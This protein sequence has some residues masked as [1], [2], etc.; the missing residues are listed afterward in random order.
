MSNPQSPNPA[1]RPDL[2]LPTLRSA[3]GDHAD[4]HAALD[5]FHAEFTGATPSPER[6]GSHAERLR[7][8]AAVAGPFERWW[9][10][11]KVQAFIAGLEAT[12]V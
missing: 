4:A 11:P 3:A 7:G 12:G 8:F 6:L 1:D 10:D 2:P 5:D 9:L